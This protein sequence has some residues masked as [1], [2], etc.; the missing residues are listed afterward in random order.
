MK[1]AREDIFHTRLSKSGLITPFNCV[2]ECTKALFGI[3]SQYQQFSEISLFNRVKEITPGDLD[4]FFRSYDI[5]KLWGQRSTVHLYCKE[6]WKYISKIYGERN[7]FVVTFF[8]DDSTA[9]KKGLKAIEKEALQG[10][11]SKKTVK[12]ILDKEIPHIQNEYRDY[13]FLLKSTLDGILFALPEKPHTKHFFHR[14]FLFAEKDMI[15]WNKI[16]QKEALSQLLERYF[17]AYGPASFKDF[18]HWSGLKKNEVHEAFQ[19]I[20][21]Q[22]TSFDYNGNELFLFKEDPHLAA[23]TPSSKKHIV[24]LLGKFDPLF[25]CY[26]DKT[27][28]M[29]AEAFK[30]VWRPAA[31]V[32]SVLIV[33]DEAA[34]TWRYA[35]SGR[36]ISYEIHSFKKIS[37]DDKK[38]IRKEA[39]KLAAFLSKDMKEITYS[40]L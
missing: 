8:K 20:R 18:L 40:Q 27:W 9:L 35:L 5:I 24:R 26:A 23:L 19:N 14:S 29:P 34:G 37:L 36:Q 11:I 39:E 13:G 22:L 4:Q 10:R 17:K 3:Q 1:L 32:E 12:A 28:A 31:H 21:S 16:T 38:Q 7:N 2:Q 33:G 30:H 15:E 25:V 6:D